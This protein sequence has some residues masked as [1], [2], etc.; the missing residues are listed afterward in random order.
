MG[1]PQR[2]KRARKFEKEV[3]G[4]DIGKKHPSHMHLKNY[5]H[6]VKE[7][8]AMYILDQ[9]DIKE[10]MRQLKKWIIPCCE[11]NKDYHDTYA[12]EIDKKK[13]IFIKVFCQSCWAKELQ[14]EQYKDYRR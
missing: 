3:R 6:K 13:F 4:V 14:K 11:N 1:C 5:K 8:T 10:Y 12:M 9:L 2:S 7:V